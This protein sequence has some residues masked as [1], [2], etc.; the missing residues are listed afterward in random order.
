MT[1]GYDEVEQ[2]NLNV[3]QSLE[4]YLADYFAGFGEEMPPPGLYQRILRMVEPP[5]ITAA[6]TATRGNQIRASELLGLNRNTLR[7]KIRDLEIK[8]VRSSG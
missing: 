7:K 4:L 3:S 5:L 1:A 8:V 2:Q 6:L